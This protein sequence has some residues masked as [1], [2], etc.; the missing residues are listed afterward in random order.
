MSRIDE[1][2]DNSKTREELIDEKNTVDSQIN[3]LHAVITRIKAEGARGKFENP[4]KFEA[5]R[6]TLANLKAR[7]Q[8]I[9]LLLGTMPRKPRTGAAVFPEIFIEIAEQELDPLTFEIIKQK[10]LRELK[11]RRG[12]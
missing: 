7:S 12:E 2:L 3:K 4:D 1:R 11:Q 6:R 9:Q 10:A 8:E 5:K